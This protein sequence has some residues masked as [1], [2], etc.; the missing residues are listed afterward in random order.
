MKNYSRKRDVIGS[1]E[2]VSETEAAKLLGISLSDLKKL[3]QQEIL[4]P[5]SFVGKTN[6]FASSDIAKIKYKKKPTLS[7]EAEVINAQIQRD[8]TFS[9]ST[10]QKV[11][12]IA[13]G[14]IITYCLIVVILALLFTITPWQTAAWLGY[15]PRIESPLSARS[16]DTNN[17]VLA[18]ATIANSQ[19]PP[20]VVQMILKPVSR[21][22]LGIIKYVSP[23]TYAEVGKITILDVNDVIELDEKGA[24]TPLQTVKFSKSEL[25]EMTDS[26]LVDNLNSEFLQ[27]RKPGTTPG[28]IAIVGENENTETLDS[29][30]SDLTVANFDSSDISQWT[31]NS[32]YITASS[33]NTLTNKTFTA[34]SN[35]ISGLTNS[36]LS[37][38]A[39][40]TNANLANSSITINTTSPLTGGG[41]VVLGDT[42]TLKCSSC[43]VSSGDL[44]TT[45]ASSGSN[46]TISSGGTLT[47]SA[48]SNILTSNNGS[49]TISIALSSTPTVTSINGLSITNNGSN[50]L[51]IAAGKTLTTS[52]SL[53]FAGTD[54][55][56]FTFPGSSDTVA[57]I[58]ASQTLTNKTITAGSNTISGLSTSNFSS[59]NISQWTNDSGFI[60]ASTS[61]TLTNKT[62]AAGSNTIT[63]LTNSNLSG[64]AGITNAN[65]ANSSLTVTAG[66]GLSGGGLVSL[67][68]S[69]SLANSGVL[70]LTGTSN[71]VN[72]SAASGSITVSLPQNVDTGASPTFSVLNL[73]SNSNQLLLGTTNVGTLTWSPSTTRILTLPDITDTLVAKTTSDV[74]TNKTLTA[75]TINGTVATTGLTLPAFT[76]SGNI[77][78]SGSPT[79]SGFGSFNGLTLTAATD[80]F[81]IAGGT[82]SRTLTVT[83][84]DVTIGSTIKPTSAGALTIQSNGTFQL[85]IDA[86]GGAGIHIGTNSASSVTVG[87]SGV[88]TTINGTADANN[89][90]IGSG[91]T[92]T[93]HL[94]GT[95][96][97]DAAG[98]ALGSCGNLGTIT[99]TGA[100]AGDTVVAT[101]TPVSNGVET[102][103]LIWNAYVSSTNTVTI[104]ACSVATLGTQNPDSQTWRADVWQH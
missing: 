94:S 46:S 24:L 23:N 92:I 35:T 28:D 15:M 87:R 59:A 57:G 65:L 76:A 42:I 49:G 85:F 72:V 93:K 61:D 80:G 54:G 17:K 51:N 103:L 11:L 66:T 90:K 31:N 71:Q 69:V 86:G 55:T 58:A 104:R 96:T 2:T 79:I 64:T 81:T 98:I 63:G 33:T 88:T 37:G 83:G 18:A 1:T 25:L 30:I 101:P 82:T 6:Y 45:A 27:G 40:I 21:T 89:L 43:S 68:S 34:G 74:L 7:E 77:T 19:S 13:G 32:G 5:V 44:F 60:T 91:T 78:G 73:S 20:S 4:H 9:L 39:G 29:A 67:G 16:E 62:I 38:S 75:P 102:L 99:V 100:A 10:L 36:N 12:I 52:N 95:N 26:G 48:G 14:S 3:E 56:T 70:S 41:I 22:S 50:T 47:L 84:A 97:F 8:I 53:T